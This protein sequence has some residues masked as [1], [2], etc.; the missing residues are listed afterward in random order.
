MFIERSSARI[1]TVRTLF[2]LLGLIP[3]AGLCGW[4][5]LRHSAP[6][7]RDVEGRCELLLGLPV[8]IDRVEHV[9]PDAVRLHGCTV[10]SPD[11]ET[12]LAAAVVDVESSSTEV[13][14]RVG[15]VDCSPPLARSAAA[16][17]HQWLRQP[18]RFPLDCVVDVGELSWVTAGDAAG[19]A[20]GLRI[21]C[22]A[23]DGGRAV[24]LS[25]G[26]ADGA[27]R[28]DELRLIATAGGAAAG[29]TDA[30][31]GRLEVT[32][33]VARP[34]PIAIL[35][36]CAGFAPDTL[37]FGADAAVSGHIE[38]S[39]EGGRWSGTA[40]GRVDRLGLAAVTASLPS[41]MSGEATLTIDRIDWARGRIATCDCR[42][43][44]ARG[45]VEQRLLDA[46]VAVIGCRPGPEYRPTAGERSRSFDEAA[47]RLRIGPAG[48]E[49]RA[50]PGRG[51]A[52]AAVR[53]TAILEEPPAA[54]PLERV[55]WLVSPPSAVAVPASP[56]TGWLLGTFTEDVL[57][58]DAPPR[59]QVRIPSEQ[60]GRSTRRSDF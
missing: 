27:G 6:H 8:R 49:L 41:R 29:A 58:G 7:R 48:L 9:R 4:A 45:M 14:L 60:A 20:A 47:G 16:L 38:C 30:S 25:G 17:V 21:E 34:V 22:V 56:A 46:L 37:P 28:E 40:G 36:A 1:R 31:G 33:A 55:A 54:V 11:G 2:V 59:E 23:A 43:V 53:G 57:T 12:L 15:R 5:V 13:R 32:G 19:A 10:K 26:R 44:A 52:I 3:C 24:R 39:R 18:A 51:A 35:E 50:E 42:F